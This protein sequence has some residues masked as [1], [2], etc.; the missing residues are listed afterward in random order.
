MELYRSGHNEAVLKTVCP[1]GTWVRIPPAPPK[2]MKLPPFFVQR[3]TMNGGTFIFSN[4]YEASK[5][6]FKS[7]HVDSR[8]MLSFQI[9]IHLLGRF[10]TVQFHPAAQHGT[11][12][13]NEEFS[14]IFH[15]FFVLVPELMV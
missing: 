6:D 10:G 12:T 1:K 13:V 2:L 4:T 7:E 9:F 3:C 11:Q 8:G 14:V 5:P 15:F